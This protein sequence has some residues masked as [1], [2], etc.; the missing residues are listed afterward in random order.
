[1]NVITLQT[2]WNDFCT[3]TLACSSFLNRG[4][5]VELGGDFAQPWGDWRREL[6]RYIEGLDEA[7]L[8]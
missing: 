1:M 8:G 7:Y 5:E 2:H 3:P 6:A 4:K